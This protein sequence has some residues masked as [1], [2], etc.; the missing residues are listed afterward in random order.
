MKCCQRFLRVLSEF[1]SGFRK[2]A[3]GFN[4]HCYFKTQELLKSFP[5]RRNILHGGG[6]DLREVLPSGRVLRRRR[7]RR[8]NR[9]LRKKLLDG[10]TL[11]GKRRLR[12]QEQIR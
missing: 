3:S 2:T 1:G 5:G 7:R 12:R 4:S 10:K 6:D 8:R 11:S 9:R